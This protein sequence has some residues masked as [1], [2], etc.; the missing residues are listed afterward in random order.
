[1]TPKKPTKCNPT[2]HN[3]VVIQNNVMPVSISGGNETVTIKNLEVAALCSKCG[4][5]L[6]TEAVM[7]RAKIMQV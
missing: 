5:L 6:F 3:Y 2:E 1:M 4:D 7:Q